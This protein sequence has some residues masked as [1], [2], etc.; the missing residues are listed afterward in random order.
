MPDPNP[1]SAAIAQCLKDIDTSCDNADPDPVIVQRLTIMIQGRMLDHLLGRIADYYQIDDPTF[2]KELASILV[3]VFSEELFARFRKKIE[4]QPTLVFEIAQRFLETE[5]K[6]VGERYNRRF[7]AILCHYLEYE[8]IDHILMT[9]KSDS[10]I[11]K[12]VLSSLLKKN[13]NF[14]LNLVAQFV[15][16]CDRPCFFTALFV[17]YSQRIS[18]TLRTFRVRSRMATKS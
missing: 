18:P 14:R 13:L 11:Q 9:L 15:L 5:E 12:L 16:D 8:G 10:R 4:Q 7:L 17:L 3:E 6:L 2:T 1:Y